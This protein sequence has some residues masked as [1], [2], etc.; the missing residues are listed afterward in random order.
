MAFG[1]DP[2]IVEK[3]TLELKKHTNRPLILKLSPNVT[4]ISEIALAAESGGADAI[5]CINTVIGMVIDPEALRPAI[6]M[7]T[8]GLSGHANRP[9]GIAA[10]YKVSRAVHIPVIGIGGIAST[11]DALQY[12][13]AGAKAI[14]VGTALFSNPS[15]PRCILDGIA[16]W[17]IRHKVQRVSD[18]SRM[19]A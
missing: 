17:M 5:S 14:Q 16:E 13:L 1:I 3:L 18:I 12:L 6:S 4:D 2:F 8:G 11:Q 7:G 10:T 15:A 19:L 9:I